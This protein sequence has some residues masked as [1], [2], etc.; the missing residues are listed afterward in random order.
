MVR[1][2]NQLMF[3]R[4]GIGLCF[5]GP[6]ILFCFFAGCFDSTGDSE[7]GQSLPSAG[8]LPEADLASN[9][10]STIVSDARHNDKESGD[11]IK[12]DRI[13][14]EHSSVSDA[15][16]AE[17][18]T[19]KSDSPELPSLEESTP[20]DSVASND[21]APRRGPQRESEIQTIDIPD[22]WKRI[23]K[24]NRKSGVDFEKQAGHLWW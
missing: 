19:S 9:T 3:S 6:L 2:N 4:S 21:E 11:N 1:C 14:G 24:E 5:L 18:K 22:S 20:N 16:D 12:D 8:N 13:A 17:G 10:A 23:G 7:L 15:L